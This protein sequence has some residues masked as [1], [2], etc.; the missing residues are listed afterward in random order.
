MALVLFLGSKHAFTVAKNNSDILFLVRDNTNFRENRNNAR[1]T[2]RPLQLGNVPFARSGLGCLLRN[3]PT[4]PPTYNKPQF[5]DIKRRERLQPQHTRSLANV[6]EDRRLINVFPMESVLANPSARIRTSIHRDFD[7]DNGLRCDTRDR[8]G[9][10]NGSVLWF[11]V[12]GGNQR[13]FQT[14]PLTRPD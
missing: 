10:D 3:R 9:D 2:W 1:S 5:V 8:T 7:A 6:C 4:P 13:R 12:A 11:V 14:K